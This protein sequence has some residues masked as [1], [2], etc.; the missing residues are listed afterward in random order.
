MQTKFK[1]YINRGLLLLGI[2]LATSISLFTSC[3]KE[4][5]NGISGVVLESFGPM[6]IAR[7][8]ELKFF[9]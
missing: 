6:P 4:D 3:E 7:G 2:T 9:G 8:A 1:K 5:D